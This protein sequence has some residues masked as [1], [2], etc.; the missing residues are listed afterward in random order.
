MNS[1]KCLRA[2]K[3]LVTLLILCADA[4]AARVFVDPTDQTRAPGATATVTIRVE[5]DGASVGLETELAFDPVVF[6]AS[7]NALNGDCGVDNVSGTVTALFVQSDVSPLPLT[8]TS[9]C[10]VQLTVDAGAATGLQHVLDINSS[11]FSDANALPAAGPH[12]EDDGGILVQAPPPAQLISSPGNGATLLL[13]GG[14]I[15]TAT[16]GQ[17]TFTNIGGQPATGLSCNI[18]FGNG[19]TIGVAPTSTVN[20]GGGTFVQVS[21]VLNASAQ[22][23]SLS[24]SS[25][26]GSFNYSVDVPAGL[27]PVT[28]DTDVENVTAMSD[29]D[30]LAPVSDAS[31]RFIVFQ[32]NA[33]TLDPADTS[34]DSDIYLFDSETGETT[35]ISVDGIGNK[36]VGDSTAPSVSADGTA[37]IFV[38]PAAAMLKLTGESKSVAA[39]RRKGGGWVAY[40][41]NLIGAPGT[42]QISQ[43]VSNPAELAPRIAPGA[44]GVAFT[45]PNPQKPEQ[46]E[47]FQRPIVRDGLGN[48]S[49]GSIRCVS[50]KTVGSNGADTGTLSDGSSGSPVVS[51]DGRWVAFETSSKNLLVGRPSPCPNAS[52]EIVLRDLIS[53]VSQRIGAPS[54]GAGCGAAGQGARKPAMDWPGG[55]FVF[56][57]DQPLLPNDTNGLSD[58]YAFDLQAGRLLRVS[59]TDAGANAGGASR[60]PTISGDGRM[61]GFVSAAKN[62]DATTTDPGDFDDVHVR[63][64]GDSRF[65]RRLSRTR[66]G[67]ESDGHSQR[68]ALNYNGTR[69]VFD[70]AATNLDVSP[71]NGFLN[72]YRRANPLDEFTI[73]RAGFE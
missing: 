39:N 27:P 48:V 21:T 47:V 54:T 50:C 5:G 4:Q 64:F 11:Q 40:L 3:F 55:K 2:A 24:C 60:E 15:G 57:S 25:S 17:V 46:N 73:H 70:S 65:L 37:V 36:A 29:Q 8:A 62:L 68:P 26:A 30:S 12:G 20:P 44:G 1:V 38:A 42:F 59:E 63:E 14:L 32:S 41:R 16:Q 13:P 28:P 6:E 61:I 31:G 69:M 45:A 7:V 23:A 67:G 53:G 34:S 22:F 66:V 19:P 51:A 52:R 18:T 35:L 56:E 43:P 58:V 33:T 72:V 71:S 9:L 10:E 49:L